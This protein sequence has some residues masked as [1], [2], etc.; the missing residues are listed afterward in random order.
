MKLPRDLSGADLV[1]LLKRYG[2]QSTHQSGS[3]IRL[4]TQ[5]NGEHHLTIPNHQALRVGT[6]NAILGDVAIHL[7][8]EKS[9]LI[10][11]LWG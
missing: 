2:Y 10:Q 5:R 7:G 6:L 3:H 8:L 1:A 4:T 11:D 9:S